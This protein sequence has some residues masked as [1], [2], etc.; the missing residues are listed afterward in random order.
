MG[1]VVKARPVLELMGYKLVVRALPVPL[2][3]IRNRE[4]VKDLEEDGCCGASELLKLHA[5]TLKEYDRVLQIDADVHFHKNFDDLFVYNATLVWTHGGLGGTEPLNGGFLVVKP[6]Q[7]DYDKMVNII[8][9]AKFT[10]GRGWYGIC[11]WTYGARTIQGLLPYYYIHHKKNEDS[12]EVERCAYNNMVEIDR[13]KT[14]EY[15]EVSSNHFTVCEKPFQCNQVRTEL[16]ARFT[17][18][19]WN[20]LKSFEDK[21]GLPHVAKCLRGKYIPVNYSALPGGGA[22]NHSALSGGGTVNHSALSSGGTVNHSV[23]FGGGAK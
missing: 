15:K 10:R 16:C 23:L 17:A 4:Y 8:R 7:A 21:H 5:W 11:C 6:N 2:E 19:W 18:A 22:I 12:Q 14:W 9:E 1:D 3:E 20:N 13:C